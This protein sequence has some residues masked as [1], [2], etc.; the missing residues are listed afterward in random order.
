MVN[1]IGVVVIGR[2][3]GERLAA[4]LDSFAGMAAPLV[5][6][7]SGSSDGSAA[8]ARAKGVLV[9]ELDPARPFSAA[10]ARNEGLAQLLAVHPAL[11]FVQ[12]IDGDCY[13]LAGWLDAA[14]ATL[15]DHE[16]CA[17]VAGHLIER[18]PDASVYNRLCQLEWSS[19]TIGDITDAGGLGGISVMRISAFEQAGRFNPDV[20]AGEEPELSMRLRKAGW[21]VLKIDQAMATHDANILS[22]GQWWQRNVRAGH[23]IGHRSHLSASN[24]SKDCIRERNSTLLWGVALPLLIV[25]A[26]IPTH[27]AS[28]L[29][30]GGYGVL[31][32]RVWRHRRRHG[33]SAADA[34]LYARYLILSK[35]A[36]GLGLLRF[37]SNLLTGRYRIIE[38][39]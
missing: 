38:Y 37:Y 13:L 21:R 17:A 16:R 36:N 33:D 12:F 9:H 5:Y 6:V 1:G 31:A 19:S 20:I 25:A 11:E 7:D 39:K 3:E 34:W 2:N 27:G 28:L 32:W 23:A 15:R 29:L 26:L 24:G 4:C 18:R 8:M 10:R 14:L 30:L 35:F 22:F